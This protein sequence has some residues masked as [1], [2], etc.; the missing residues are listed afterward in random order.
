MLKLNFLH[1][2]TIAIVIVE[3]QKYPIIEAKKIL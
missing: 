2:L 1:P 3:H